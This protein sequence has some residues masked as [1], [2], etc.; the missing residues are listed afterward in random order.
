MKKKSKELAIKKQNVLVDFKEIRDRNQNKEN[1]QAAKS[2]I[3]YAI[4]AHL[5][6]IKNKHTRRSQNT[7]LMQLEEYFN[8]NDINTLGDLAVYT[9]GKL[10]ALCYGFLKSRSSTD[11]EFT[12][13]LKKNIM[14]SWFKTIY[15]RFRKLIEM[16]VLDSDNYK[17]CRSKGTTKALTIEQWQTLKEQLKKSRNKYLETM[18]LFSFYLGGRRVGECL[19]LKWEDI[20]FDNGDSH[21]KIVPLKKR[22]DVTIIEL[23]V[24]NNVKNVLQNFY[25]QQGEPDKKEKV[26]KTTQQQIYKALQVCCK[27]IKVEGINFH[28]LRSTFITI[29]QKKSIPSDKILN[30]TLH[31]SVDMLRY[32]DDN[33][34]KK[35]NAINDID[36]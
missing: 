29:C 2:T 14:I 19:N 17:I 8:L 36:V 9:N 25:K 22:R 7:V 3:K 28:S 35:H 4:E 31:N 13:Q 21:I 15:K 33:D 1:G 11:S 10:D 26:F 16:P 34:R 5:L 27:K 23:P 32:Y 24:P 12:V 18:C 6:E 20:S 30:A